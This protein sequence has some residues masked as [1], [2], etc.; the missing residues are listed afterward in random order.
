MKLK[1]VLLTCF[2]SL[3]VAVAQATNDAPPGN[4]GETKKNDIAGSVIDGDNKKPV[5]QVSITAIL[6][7]KKE[8]VIIADN[9]GN[10][11]FDDLKP[12]TY[13]LVFEKNGY[14]KVTKDKVVIKTDNDM[15]L[16]IEMFKEGDFE[17]VP[18]LLFDFE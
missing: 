7:D 5:S 12:G 17:F 11:S 1:M 15:Q 13:K 14:K 3:A 4:G 2:F 16:N 18:Q 8:K 6:Q 10:Y 9:N